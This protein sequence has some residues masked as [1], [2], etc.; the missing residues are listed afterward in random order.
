MPAGR[1]PENIAGAPKRA[2]Q[3]IKANK[4]RKNPPTPYITSTLQQDAANKLHFSSTHTMKV[5]GYFM[6]V[7][8]I[9]IL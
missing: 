7:I 5:W 1:K 2:K 8:Y 4:M 9:T 3:I 6:L